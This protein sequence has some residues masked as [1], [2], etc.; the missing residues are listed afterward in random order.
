MEEGGDAAGSAAHQPLL[1]LSHHIAKI[2]GV[3][4]LAAAVLAQ[5][6][7]ACRDL[8]L[9]QCGVEMAVR[10]HKLARTDAVELG[11]ALFLSH[12]LIKSVYNFVGG[13]CGQGLVYGRKLIF[14]IIARHSKNSCRYKKNNSFHSDVRW[15]AIQI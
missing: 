6:A 1:D 13:G 4:N 5:M 10:A 7:D 2:L 9:A 8:L 11:D 14:H 3:T 15:F 12:L